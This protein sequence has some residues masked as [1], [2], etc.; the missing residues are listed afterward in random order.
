MSGIRRKSRELALQVLF[1]AEFVPDRK[2]MD[3]LSY[4]RESF[5][6]EPEVFEYAEKVLSAVEKHSATLQTLLSTHSRNWSAERMA[7]VDLSILRLAFAELLEPLDVPQ[8]VV[9]NEAI[10]IAKKYG[11]TESASFVNGVLDDYLRSHA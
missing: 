7:K 8:K 2:L 10:E 1:Q 3:R 4:F 11:N 9:L 6:I 5:A